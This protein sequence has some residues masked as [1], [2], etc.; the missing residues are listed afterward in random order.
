M[1]EFKTTPR[2]GFK[3]GADLTEESVLKRF[4]VIMT[5]KSFVNTPS[6]SLHHFEIHLQPYYMDAY[7]VKPTRNSFLNTMKFG[8]SLPRGFTTD[9]L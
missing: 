2:G 5:F 8:S 3:S 4:V 6:L 7:V 9:K 1:A